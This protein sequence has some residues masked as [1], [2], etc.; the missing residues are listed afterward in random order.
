VKREELFI[1][2]KLWQTFHDEDKVEPITRKQLA[3]WQIDYFDLFLIPSSTLTPRSVTRQ[4][5]SMT[6][7]ARF[8]GARPPFNRPGVPWR[9]W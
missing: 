1:V 2:S 4:D 3:D 9:S 6:A 8:D 5:G 7:R